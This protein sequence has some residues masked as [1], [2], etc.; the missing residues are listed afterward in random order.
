MERH[1]DEVHIN[2]E[3][4]SGGSK[5][6]VVRW[7][8]IAGTLL[9]IILLSVI[10][11]SGAAT[12]GDI[13]SEATVSGRMDAADLQQAVRESD[14]GAADLAALEAGLSVL[15]YYDAA[16]THVWLVGARKKLDK[17]CAEI[18]NLLS[19]YH[20]RMSG[21]DVS[22]DGMVAQNGKRA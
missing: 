1:N 16:T 13:E 10:W 6:G 12:Q 3:E 11:I 8:L 17:K 9:A 15:V 22:F 21:K 20:W 2:E 19:H 18:R 7:V 4:V 14:S 5:E